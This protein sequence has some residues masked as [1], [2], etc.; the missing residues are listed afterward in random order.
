MG[1]CSSAGGIKGG[2]TTFKESLNSNQLPSSSSLACNSIFSKYIFD[3]IKNETNEFIDISVLPAQSKNPLSKDIE[4]YL[5]IGLLSSEDG[6]NHRAP[7]NLILVLDVSGSMQST[8]D[9]GG[10]MSK[11]EL[12]KNCV[13]NI[14]KKLMP[15]E[16]MALIT[17]DTQSRTIM[18][19]TTKAEIDEKRLFSMLGHIK[20]EG[21]TSIEVGYRPAVEMMKEQITKDSVVKKSSAN[22]IP[23]N[24]R[25]IFITDALIN[26]GEESNAL[27]KINF[28]ASLKSSNI[29]T[30]FIGVGVDFNTDLVTK[31]TKVRGS[32]Y[33]AVH[34]DAEFVK[35]LEEDFN[36]IVTPICFDVFVKLD[37]EKFEIVKTYG[38]DFDITEEEKGDEKIQMKKG[39]VLRLETLCAYEKTAGGIKGGVVLVQI[40]EKASKEE[41]KETTTAESNLIKVTIEYEDLLGNRKSED[42]MVEANFGGD[43]EKYPSDGVRKA[44]LLS[45]YVNFSKLLLE[46]GGNEIAKKEGGMFLEYFRKEMKVVKEDKNLGEELENLE[47]LIKMVEK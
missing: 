38:S 19:L 2:N 12:A 6:K 43:M 14:Y 25:I 8:M 47:M 21:G 35:T 22:E 24:H 39:G 32:N 31:L 40:K 28:Q 46:K 16:R 36:Y 3:L 45:R 23:Q 4:K 7:L 11:I 27:F 5:S 42:V 34:S 1:A 18:E 17:F 10:N 9:R 26:D 37:S 33:F 15:N 13:K 20:A 44:L 29:F 30:T 41:K